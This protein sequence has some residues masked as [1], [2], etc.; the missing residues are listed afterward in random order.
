MKKPPSR[1]ASPNCQVIAGAFAAVDRPARRRRPRPGRCSR[2]HPGQRRLGDQRTVVGLGV[3]AVADPQV[4]DPFDQPGAQPICGLLADRHRHADGHAPLARAAVAGADERVDGLVQVGVG[5]HDHVVLR[6]AEALRTLSRWPPQSS[7]CSARCRSCRRSRPPGCRGGARMASTASLSPCTT[8]NTPSGR[9]ASVNSSA[10]RTGTDGSRSLGLRMNAFPHASAG[11]AFHSGI[12]A[13]KL[14]GVIPA[15][16][17]KRLAQRVDVDTCAGALGVLALEQVRDADRRTRS[18]RCRA[19]CRRGQSGSVLPCSRDSS[20]ASSS[21][22]L[23]TSSTKLHHHPGPALR[24]PRRPVF[25]GLDRR[26]DRGVDVG[27]RAPSAPAPAPR[28]V[29]G[30]RTSAVRVDWPAVRCP[31]MKCGICV[32]MAVQVSQVESRDY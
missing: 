17:P 25:L 11:P 6:A 26:G 12:I 32:V 4:V 7:R 14:N 3:Q 22:F 29:L 20:S 2:L 18:P 10:N 5:H 24:I 16:T 28:P 19:G 1:F 21:M 15:T 23:L 9:P 31:S 8:W 30:L 13:G 27:R